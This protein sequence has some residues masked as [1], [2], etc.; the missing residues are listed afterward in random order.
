MKTAI[1]YTRISTED[2]SHF[3]I[4]GQ[5]AQIRTYCQHNGISIAR[6]FIDS[7]FSAKNFHRPGWQQLKEYLKAE[8]GRIGF[9]IVFKYDRM[10]RNAMEGLAQ[11]QELERTYKLT[12]ISVSENLGLSPFSPYFKKVRA[13][14]LVNAEFER[15]QISER[16]RS[17][18]NQANKS[19]RY[20]HQA[21][22]GYINSRDEQNKPIL[23][24]DPVKAEIIRTM[25]FEFADGIPQKLIF[26]KAKA[27]GLN[28]RG[29]QPVK[30]LLTN[31]LYCGLIKVP[32]FHGEPETLT[33]GIHQAIVSPELFY[34]VQAEF[35]KK[36]KTV[37]KAAH[38]SFPFR[39]VIK[40]NKGHLLTA[41]YCTG[42]TGRKWP[43]Y[44]CNHC[45][46]TYNADK[47]NALL[48]QILK[49]LK[50][51][52]SL[53]QDLITATKIEFNKRMATIS[54]RK[55]EISGQIAAIQHKI[56][57]IENKLFTQIISDE[58][59]TRHMTSLSTELA[60]LQTMKTQITSSANFSDKLERLIESG[61]DDISKVFQSTNITDQQHMLRLIFPRGLILLKGS[62][63]TPSL[64]P[65]LSPVPSIS[66]LLQIK[67][68]DEYSSAPFGGPAGAEIKLFVEFILSRTA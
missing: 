52:Q 30:K 66:G 6:E 29:K 36:S 47:S 39:G 41:C 31:P 59:Y 46:G 55:K 35:K 68:A 10:I 1:S 4:D 62:Y 42:K 23:V 11:L 54:D 22:F 44:K 63:Q 65:I 2:Q 51:N 14:I 7:G 34:F 60:Q 9:L 17:G 57:V 13:D 21:P 56:E 8:R 37:I 15:D 12:I 3:S 67:G 5:L 58:T 48:L 32:A 61:I 53:V 33:K 28:H 38:P 24:I 40:C 18:M 43:Y 49:G 27:A 20:L 64:L 45:G 16:V 50:L 19:G 25:F 26:D